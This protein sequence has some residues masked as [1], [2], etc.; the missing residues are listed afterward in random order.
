MEHTSLADCS[1]YSGKEDIVSSA[2]TADKKPHLT[3]ISEFRE[4]PLNTQ[5]YI[6]FLLAIKE[7]ARTRDRDAAQ[8]ALLKWRDQAG[9]SFSMARSICVIVGAFDAVE[10]PKSFMDFTKVKPNNI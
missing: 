6:D 7:A 8:R 3:E 2:E 4:Y 9:E 5:E 10:N 1:L